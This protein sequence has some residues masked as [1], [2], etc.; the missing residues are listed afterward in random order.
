[1]KTY[2]HMWR[3]I[4][5]R[6]RLYIV[7]AVL[8]ILIHLA[9][10]VPGLIAQQF[11][12]T[13]QKT[14]HLDP[15]LWT[16]IALLITTALARICLIFFGGL[17]DTTHRF[18]MSALLRRN[19][20]ARILERPGA[21]A[22]PHSTGEALN[23]FRDDVGQAEDAISWTLDSIGTTLFAGIAIVM[24]LRLNALVT[25]LVFVP[26]V[27]VIALAQAM[28][29]RLERYRRA[30]RQAT[31]QVASAIG[32]IFS[33]VQAIKVAAAEPS[34]LAHFQSLSEDRRKTMLRDRVLETSIESTIGNTVGL[35]T[36]LILILA[37]QA[38]HN[39]QLG[40]GDLAIF[41][42]YLAFVSDFTQFFG[43]F[44]AHY[45]QTGVSF[46]RMEEL[47]QGAPAQ[48]LDEAHP[49]HLKGAL[50]LASQNRELPTEPLERLEV[51]NVSYHYPDTGRGISNISFALSVGSLTVITGRIASG[52]TT[53]LQALLGLLPKDTGEIL[54]NGQIIDDPA[55]FLTPPH[56][57]YTAQIPRL[58][59]A[60]LKENIL[61][62]QP[63][64]PIR[65]QQALH[66]AVME[67]DL[68]QLEHGL[69]TMIGTRGVKLSG[70][71]TQRSAA[72]RMFVRAAELLVFDDLSS[73][74]D[75][76]TEQ[77]LWQRLFTQRQQTCL[78]VSH[79]RTVLQQA[80]QILVLKD[81]K[82]EACGK[83]A[84][85][86]QTSVEM[87]ALWHGEL[88]D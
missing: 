43:L 71:Q 34:V 75:V 82:V 62:D 14:Q 21:R 29:T 88:I 31:G 65:L 17:V 50:S 81:G 30:S 26:L 36:G 44:L 77:L 7:N 54:W 28:H 32:E 53:L 66:T 19:L 63:E 3:L 11:F 56:S 48:R 68:E 61:L 58:F 27:G 5:Y 22:V 64:E 6:P 86:L 10:I 60:S 79:R 45:A 2:Q 8:W 18:S 40:I 16:L 59:S 49:L 41:I 83:L 25:L 80:D 70:G 74:L 73:A 39:M 78:V 55:T 42:Y 15:T 69:E 52:K 87:Q 85:L 38:L 13:L 4:R 23:R 24:L 57:A 37:A 67:H 76:K 51:R 47:L 35:G 20:L 84:T 33:T 12:N 72:A 1:M 46:Q 9:P